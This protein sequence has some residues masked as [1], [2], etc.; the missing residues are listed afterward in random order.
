ME[1][2]TGMMQVAEEKRG[3]P[4]SPACRLSELEEVVDGADHRPLSPD[5]IKAS[6]QELPEASGL[7]DLPE[8]GLHHLLAQPVTAF[9]ASPLEGLSHGAHQR[10][11]GQLATSRSMRLAMTCPPRRQVAL[12]PALLQL[13]E[14]R[15]R[16]KARIP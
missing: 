12:D 16:G 14:V 2:R 1:C 9:P 6:Q 4:A 15:L 10:L 3:R 8:H 11:L 5:L 13:S 7:L